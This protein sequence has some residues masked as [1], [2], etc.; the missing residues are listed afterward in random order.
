M[1]EIIENSVEKILFP[2]FAQKR[3]RALLKRKLQGSGK[4]EHGKR[5]NTKQLSGR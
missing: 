5:R 2:M 1:E 3:R 4:R